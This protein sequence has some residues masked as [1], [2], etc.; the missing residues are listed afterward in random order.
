[1]PGGLRRDACA[2]GAGAAIERRCPSVIRGALAATARG[3]SG[4][5]CR[6]AT[7]TGR[8]PSPA[9]SEAAKFY[10]AGVAD[11]AEGVQWCAGGGVLRHELADRVYTGL[12]A[13]PPAPL[14]QRASIA[15]IQ[16]LRASFPCSR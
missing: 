4:C 7:A 9:A 13:L 6:A 15:V 8:T 16:A 10:I 11:G 5:R 12:S 1:M 2:G 14:Q 3:R